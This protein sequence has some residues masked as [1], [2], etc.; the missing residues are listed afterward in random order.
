MVE[1]G[2][3]GGEIFWGCGLYK[4]SVKDKGA[5]KVIKQ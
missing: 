3:W 4:Y 1:A 2:E 5:L